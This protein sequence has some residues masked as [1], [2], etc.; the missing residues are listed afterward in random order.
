MLKKNT[1]YYANSKPVNKNRNGTGNL[2]SWSGIDILTK[3]T[4]PPPP[5]KVH[6]Y[7]SNRH[8]LSTISCIIMSPCENEVKLVSN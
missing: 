1:K 4:P 6:E 3:A 8:T 5:L 7:I 2:T